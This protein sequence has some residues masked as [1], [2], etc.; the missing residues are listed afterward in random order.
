V[1]VVLNNGSWGSEK[2]YQ[3]YAFNERYVGADTTNPRFDKYAELFGG[4]GFYVD[5]PADVGPALQEALASDIPSIIEI[6]IDPDELPRPARL[7]EVQA[8]T[9]R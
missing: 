3:K 8:P 2:A 1:S 6:P 5:D 7:A 4:R 9:D